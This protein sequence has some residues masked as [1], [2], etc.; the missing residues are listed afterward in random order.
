MSDQSVPRPRMLPA[1][2]IVAV[3]LIATY[4]FTFRANTGVPNTI[5]SA[6]VP[7]LAALALAIWWF[8]QKS[9]PL[10]QRLTG[11][12]LVVAAVTVATLFGGPVRFAMLF[13]ALPVTT[14]L[15]VAALAVTN[16]APWRVQGATA[17]ATVITCGVVFSLMRA[18]NIKQNFTADL[19]W[20]WA[21]VA[22]EVLQSA[23]LDTNRTAD[24]PQT[25]SPSDWP[26]F[27]G[28]N[29]DGRAVGA[30]FATNWDE[31]PPQE[32]WRQPVGLGWSSFCVVG[33]YVFTQEQRGDGELVVCYEADT[34]EQVWVNKIE[35]RFHDMMGDGPRATPT[36][37]DGQL[38][39]M[40]ATGTVQCID[41]STG[42]AV[43]SRDIADDTGAATPTWGFSSSPLVLDDL[44]IVFS[45]QEGQAAVAYDRATGDLVWASGAAGHG[46]SS[47][48]LAVLSGVPQVLFSSD[49]GIQAFLP[50]TGEVLWGYEWKVPQPR[51]VQPFVVDG[52][53]VIHGTSN[54]TPARV[55]KVTRNDEA[56]LVEEGWTAKRFRPYFNDFVEHD[57]YCY[58]Y[59]G[60]RLK[61]MDLETGE[62]MWSGGRY[63]GQVLLL[64]AIDAVL[65]LAEDGE[66]L[67]LEATP[68]KE[69]VIARLRALDSKTW[70]HP[71]VANGKLFLRN[72]REAVCYQL[73]ETTS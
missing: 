38:F 47:G 6:V 11:F 63:G 65:L 1:V 71:V 20:K 19:S 56:W 28:P 45:G 53:T 66:V 70:N 30:T 40:G 61:C 15:A 46:Y 54:A 39:T 7:V 24:A 31:Q 73:P 16:M 57:G 22:E 13:T 27:R 25:A 72:D 35:S 67:L 52:E 5:G 58:G 50:E 3:Q 64:P 69:T 48:Q 59:D 43:W 8:R 32:L 34:G 44:V 49:T 68:E 23:E 21:P 18:D 42:K 37:V 51:C 2:V 60:S 10:R 17:A 36:F 41:A 29:R 4:F 9:V 14:T 55:L 26:G 33:D 12:G 62:I